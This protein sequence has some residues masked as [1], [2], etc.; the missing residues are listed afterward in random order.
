MPFQEIGVWPES[1]YFFF[2]FFSVFLPFLGSLPEPQLLAYARATAAWDPSRL[3]S[4]PQLT[5]KL[6]P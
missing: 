4:T 3:R 6:D 1:P 2:F 5:A